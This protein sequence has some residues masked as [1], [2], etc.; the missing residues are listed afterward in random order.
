MGAAAGWRRHLSGRAEERKGGRATVVPGREAGEGRKSGEGREV[1]WSGL[2]EAAQVL[3]TAAW[4]VCLTPGNQVELVLPRP[5]E[6]RERRG[7]E[8]HG[9]EWRG[10][11]RHGEAWRRR[12]GEVECAG[13]WS[14]QAALQLANAE[15]LRGG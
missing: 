13:P 7:K 3:G 9:E 12:R 8:R 2:F 5:G 4:G 10:E 14:V 11:E 6:D 1:G 15:W